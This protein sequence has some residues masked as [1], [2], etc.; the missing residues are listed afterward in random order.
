MQTIREPRSKNRAA[1]S[2]SWLTGQP[3][4]HPPYW[5]SVE[6]FQTPVKTPV[7]MSFS[8]AASHL[9]EPPAPSQDV[10]AIATR[11]DQ[12]PIPC[13]IWGPVTHSTPSSRCRRSM[14]LATYSGGYSVCASIRTT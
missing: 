1:S 6:R 10:S 2:E 7:S 13:G 3:S 14:P 12:G 5:S 9:A 8:S 4:S 11:R